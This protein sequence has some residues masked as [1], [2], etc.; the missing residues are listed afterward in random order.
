MDK[1]M[2]IPGY[3]VQIQTPT[4]WIL[5]D[6]SMTAQPSVFSPSSILPPPSSSYAFIPARKNLATVQKCSFYFTLKIA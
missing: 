6:C 3:P 4:H 5:I 2:Y 1:Y